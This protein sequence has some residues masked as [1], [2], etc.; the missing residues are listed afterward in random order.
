MTDQELIFSALHEV[1]LIVAAHLKSR[2]GDADEAIT[3]LMA[4]LD[5]RELAEAMN[6][7]KRRYGL[8][9]VK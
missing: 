5:T 4:V 2:T 3:Q 9:V 6:R 1:G 8:G 7:A